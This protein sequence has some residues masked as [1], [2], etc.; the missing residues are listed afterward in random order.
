[1][2]CVI[3]GLLAIRLLIIAVGEIAR[4]FEEIAED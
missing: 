4:Y 3:I 1:M 2:E